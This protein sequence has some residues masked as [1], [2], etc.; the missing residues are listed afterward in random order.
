MRVPAQV[1]GAC[2][3]FACTFVGNYC[4]RKWVHRPHLQQSGVPGDVRA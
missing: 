1:G 4:L 3:V 2:I